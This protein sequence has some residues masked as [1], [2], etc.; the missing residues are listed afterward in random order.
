MFAIAKGDRCDLDNGFVEETSVMELTSKVAPANHPYISFTG[1]AS[2]FRVYVA[3][4]AL[5][6][7]YV[8]THQ[9]RQFS[10]CKDP[11]RLRVWPC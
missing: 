10:M 11:A 3:N 4:V 5:H 7:T 2:H 9:R 8:R 1:G 6:E